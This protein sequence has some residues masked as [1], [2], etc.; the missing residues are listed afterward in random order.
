MTP[1]GWSRIRRHKSLFP[2]L[3]SM[4]NF[5]S[6]NPSEL[7]GHLKTCGGSELSP[8]VAAVR[9]GKSGALSADFFPR[10]R[11]HYQERAA[12]LFF[13]RDFTIQTQSPLVSFTFDDFPRSALLTGGAILN[14]FGLSGTY[15]VSLGLLGTEAPTGQIATAD[16]LRSAHEQGH[17]LGCHTF[18]HC[19][20]WKT[21]PQQYEDSIIKNRVAL[22]KVIPGAAFRSFAYPISSPRPLAKARVAR[23]FLCC[24]GGG[25]T[26]NV[27][28]ADL[29]RLSAY[30]L[31][32]SRDEIQAV[33]D[34]IDQ[35]RERRGWL[36]FATHDI[37]ES[38]TPYGCTPAFFEEVVQYAVGSGARILPVASALQAL[39]TSSPQ[40]CLEQRAAG[41]SNNT[42]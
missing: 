12:R 32:K 6:R 22:S 3:K 2:Y 1:F 26:I 41:R 24:R 20:P 42:L 40:S 25:Q 17:E 28:T 31:E 9:R 34:V 36:I 11:R 13:R 18:F 39:R 37:S 29:N 35:N 7:P 15:Y 21:K 16:D 30:F 10:L 23:H 27:S 33:K 4:T 8:S 19:D 5:N 14:R 38:P